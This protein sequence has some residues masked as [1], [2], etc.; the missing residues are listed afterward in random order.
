MV[1][2]TI[3]GTSKY[4]VAGLKIED[5]TNTLSGQPKTTYTVGRL[6]SGQTVWEKTGSFII[7][8]FQQA[9]IIKYYD[10]IGLN[11]KNYFYA[12]KNGNMYMHVLGSGTATSGI[13]KIDM[14]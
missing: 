13:Y 10:F 9:G 11:G 8:N 2:Q 6:N 7:E 1:S 3:G 14:N 12:D 4:G 5:P